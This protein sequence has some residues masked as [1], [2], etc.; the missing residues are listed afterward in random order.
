MCVRSTSFSLQIN[1]E[2]VDYFEGKRGL[3]QGDPISPLLFTIAMD[4]LSSLLSGL[5]KKQGFYHHPK[6]HRVDLKHLIFADDLFLFSSGRCS[7]V[8]VLKEALG[9]FLQCSGLE[10]NSDKSQLFL[11]GMSEVNK[12]WV[13]SLLSCTGSE[14]PVRYLGV[15]LTSKSISSQDCSGISQRLT[16]RLNY[17]SNRFLS[18]AGKRVLIISVLQAIVFYWARICILPKKVLQSIN[19]LC[20]S[21]LWNGKAEGRGCHLIS[22]NAVC[23][24]KRE[25]GIGIKDLEVMNEALVLNQLWDLNRNSQSIWSCWVREYWTKGIH[26]WDNP[27]LISSSWVL[28]RMAFCKNLSS[29][30]TEVVDGALRWTGEG[31]GFTVRDTYRTLKRRAE[32]VDWSNLAWN[33]FNTPRASFNAVL[34]AKDRLLTRSRLRKMRMNVDPTCVLCNVEEESRDHLFFQCTV[35]QEICGKVLKFLGVTGVPTH[36]HVLIPWFKNLNQGRIRTRL[37][38]AAISGSMYEIWRARNSIIFREESINLDLI[39]RS[40]IW[41]LK[42]KIGGIIGFVSSLQDRNWLDSIGMS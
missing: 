40:I 39:S 21:F 1:G 32:E 8:A 3:R 14:L 37:I 34:V 35:S 28:R 10:V 26:W 33:R 13:E 25:G 16:S 20:A 41:N 17:W 18:R 5:S 11:A 15:P 23:L 19:S 2:L 9:K 12:R 27:H 38:A 24:D 29:K 7:S 4:Y 6:C 30:C 42:T 36:W 22:W 31:K